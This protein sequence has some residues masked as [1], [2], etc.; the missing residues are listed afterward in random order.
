[1]RLRLVLESADGEPRDV[2]I[3]CNAT[4]TAM[5]RADAIADAATLKASAVGQSVTDML[6]ADAN[7]AQAVSVG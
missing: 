2:V 1:M 6:A 7:T 4:A 3:S 5:T